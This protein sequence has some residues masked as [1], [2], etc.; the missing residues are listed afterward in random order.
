MEIAV[1]HFADELKVAKIINHGLPCIEID[2][3]KVPL[4][5]FEEL[6][7]LLFEESSKREWLHHPNIES[8]K[9]NLHQQ[10]EPILES[11]TI[12]AKRREAQ[13]RNAAEKRKLELEK[14][15]LRQAKADEERRRKTADFKALSFDKKLELLLEQL[16]IK[17]HM[18][19]V[20]LD[21]KVQVLSLL[22]CHTGFGS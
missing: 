20:F 17:K 2:A 15:Q 22:L 16:G 5:G 19:P 7:K 4:R 14:E 21:H 10:L 12:R 8:A 11:A 9:L 18:V 1:K 6:A 13:L 3:S